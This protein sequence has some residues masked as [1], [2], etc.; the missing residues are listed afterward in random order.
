MGLDLSDGAT[1]AAAVAAVNSPVHLRHP[2]VTGQAANE[3]I[4][5][6]HAAFPAW[7]ATP[8]D[9]RAACLDR[10]ADLLESNRDELMAI[11]VQEA[12]KTIPDAIGEVREAADFCRYYAQQA[13]LN[14]HPVDL[15]RA[16][17]RT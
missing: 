16:D 3:A 6:A 11:C 8:I 1:L 10:L 17:R 7:S 12:F 13:R 5:R 14:L 9:T 4:T 15:P 2:G